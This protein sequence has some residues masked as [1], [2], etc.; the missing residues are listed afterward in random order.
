MLPDKWCIK[1]TNANKE[2]LSKWR[3]DGDLGNRN[4]D[5]LEQPFYLHTPMEERN[6]YN[7][8]RIT[9]GYLEITFQEFEQYV[10]N[11]AIPTT[12]ENMKYLEKLLKRWNIR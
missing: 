4:Y 10:L 1:V 9:P 5:N 7:K 2:I 12:N 3:T 6:G 11:K 8:E